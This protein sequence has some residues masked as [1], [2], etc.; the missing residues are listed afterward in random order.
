MKAELS[1]TRKVKI[2]IGVRIHLVMGNEKGVRCLCVYDSGA[3][4]YGWL[5]S[6]HTEDIYQD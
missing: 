5:Y 2:G 4:M 3:W 6:R 1:V